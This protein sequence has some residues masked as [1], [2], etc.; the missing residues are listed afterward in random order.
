MPMSEGLTGMGLSPAPVLHFPPPPPG[1]PPVQQFM[2]MMSIV[3]WEHL[4]TVW[5]LWWQNQHPDSSCVAFASY[6]SV[7]HAVSLSKQISPV[8]H[9]QNHRVFLCKFPEQFIVL[10]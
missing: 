8:L 7:Q 6:R 4:S 9:V 5:A 2:S 3:T 1:S 10:H